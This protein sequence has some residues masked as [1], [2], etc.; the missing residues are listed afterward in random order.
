MRI[1]RFAEGDRGRYGLVDGDFVR[2]LVAPPWET[3]GNPELAG[4]PLEREGL[5]LL[6]PV[7][8]GK[9]LGIGRNYRAHAAELGNEVPREPLVFLKPTTA[10]VPHHGSIVL[11]RDAGRVDYEGEL[12]IVIGRR[13]RHVPK[14]EWASVVFGYAAA[15]DVTARELQKK[16]GQWW[17]AK[18]FDTFCPLGPAVEAG[19]DPSDLLLTTTVN[20]ETRQSGRTS[21]MIFDVGDIVAW[22]SAAMTLEPGDVILTGT[23]EGVAPL[24]VGQTVSVAIEK[25][26]KL[27]V[28]V[29]AEA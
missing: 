24:A 23:P 4:A 20:G 22:I 7:E 27:T 8:P 17:R 2:P 25:V 18:G 26:G 5:S 9:I 13:A 21:D 11:P 15:L 6:V 12:A 1:V 28:T 29:E 16:D 14:E 19:V 10:L 3:G